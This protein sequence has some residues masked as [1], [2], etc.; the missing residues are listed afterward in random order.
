MTRDNA[1]ANAA[2]EIARARVSLRAAGVLAREGLHDD[3]IS[4]A[5]Y[6]AF[7]A[8]RALLFSIGE[9]PRTHAGV[10]H[11]FNVRFVRTGR[12]DARHLSALSRAQ[13]DR[14]AADYGTSVTFTA[15][16]AAEQIACARDLV[17]AA[18]ALLA[19]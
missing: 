10:V 13:H 6:A 19:G 4:D 12:I 1:K 18:E 14:T 7:H 9:E 16:D 15:E 3:A 5:Y 2:S 11:L 17:D 8:V